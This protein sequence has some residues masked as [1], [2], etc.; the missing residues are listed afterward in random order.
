[1]TSS[2]F[3]SR[4]S[5]LGRLI[6][7][8]REERGWGIA[9]YVR[10]YLGIEVLL[11]DGHAGT[12]AMCKWIERLES[13]DHDVSIPTDDGREGTRQLVALAQPFLSTRTADEQA[14]ILHSF[15]ASLSRP[16]PP[17][18]HRF[19][20]QITRAP[21]GKLGLSNAYRAAIDGGEFQTGR[22]LK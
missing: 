22:W 1:M 13:G 15:A 19:A 7:R 2:Q 16:A 10:R 4:V 18:E 20:I 12:S 9:G 6:H 11:S 5:P 17:E 8:L 14:T 3:T 21:Y